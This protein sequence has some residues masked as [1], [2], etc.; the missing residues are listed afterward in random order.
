LQ[1]PSPLGDPPFAFSAV[2]MTVAAV[3]VAAAAS[4]P[5]SLIFR[6]LVRDH[7]RELIA[8]VAVYLVAIATMAVLATNVGVLAAAV[9]AVF[10]VVSDAVLA[11]GRFVRPVPRGKLAVH[12]TYHLAQ[13]LLVLSLVH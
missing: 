6:S 2:G 8:P 1:P 10:F 3:I 4:V 13:V 12:V 9:G 11:V 7:H 5:A